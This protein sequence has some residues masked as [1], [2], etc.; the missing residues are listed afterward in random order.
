MPSRALPAV[1]RPCDVS[2]A[3][4]HDAAAWDDHIESCKE[5]LY[6]MHQMARTLNGLPPQA[7][8]R[9]VLRDAMAERVNRALPHVKAMVVAIRQ[10]DQ[11]KALESG[12][13][14]LAVM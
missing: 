8:G 2:V 1:D 9:G 13:A 11:A 3:G 6:E 10:R 5:C 4:E 14:A 12:K 7:N